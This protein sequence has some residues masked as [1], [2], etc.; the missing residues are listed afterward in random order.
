MHPK[1]HYLKTT[2]RSVK[3]PQKNMIDL[4]SFQVTSS[5]G[6]LRMS[7]QQIYTV[8]QTDFPPALT[9]ALLLEPQTPSLS[10]A[11]VKPNNTQQM[12]TNPS[13]VM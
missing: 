10:A 2:K 5:V 13:A 7:N 4:F 3:Y 8:A 9:I 6:K 12:P 11:F 1:T